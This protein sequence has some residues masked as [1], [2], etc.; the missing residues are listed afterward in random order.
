MSSGPEGGLR[1]GVESALYLDPNVR[2]RLWAESA[3]LVGL[4]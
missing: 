2:T 1:K 4:S 3:K